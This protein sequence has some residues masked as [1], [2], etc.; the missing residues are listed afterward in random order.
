MKALAVM[1]LYMVGASPYA[2]KVQAVALEHGLFDRIERVIANPHTLPAELIAVNPLSKVPTLVTDNGMVLYDST[3][4]CLYLD[5]IGAGPSLVP[6]DGAERWNVLRR[7][8]LAHGI[9][10]AAVLQRVEGWRAQEPD[11]LV[12]IAK[13]KQVCWRSLDLFETEIERIGQVVALDTLTLA[14]AVGF[15][16]FRFPDDRWRDG[17]PRLARWYEGIA[18]RPS[19][20]RSAPYD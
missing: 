16:D 20:Q 14:C 1:K 8:A 15:L 2:R 3:V 7:H 4:I 11:R 9:L 13:Q 18:E 17:R 12:N 19:L 6:G 10:D 5:S